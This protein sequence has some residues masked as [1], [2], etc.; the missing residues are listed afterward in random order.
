MPCP[1]KAGKTNEGSSAVASVRTASSTSV[2]VLEFAFNAPQGHGDVVFPV[3]PLYVHCRH[4]V[5]LARADIFQMQVGDALDLWVAQEPAGHGALDIAGHSL[6][7]EEA[8]VAFDQHDGDYRQQDAHQNGPDGVRHGGSGDLV[9]SY[10]GESDEQADQGGPVLGEDGA[11]RGVGALED[12]LQ[13]VPVKLARRLPDCRN[14][15]MKDTP[16]RTKAMV[17]TM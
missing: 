12:L 16:S 10:P 7:H 9:Q 5:E 1:Y 15:W 2:V 11:Q 4:K 13:G 14:A 8:P 6:A 3:V 17:R